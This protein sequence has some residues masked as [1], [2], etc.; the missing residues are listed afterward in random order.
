MSIR[1]YTK[2]PVRY[3]P[4]THEAFNTIGKW[5]LTVWQ[6]LPVMS[7]NYLVHYAVKILRIHHRRCVHR[8]FLL[9]WILYGGSVG[10]Y[11]SSTHVYGR[12]ERGDPGVWGKSL[13]KCR[14]QN[15]VA[16]VSLSLL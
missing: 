12:R 10:D 1:V 14:K 2:K 9:H 5:L 8:L 3:E 11:W 4:R 7:L 13:G 15:S 16:Q 6:V